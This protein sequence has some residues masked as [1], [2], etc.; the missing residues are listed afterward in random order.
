MPSQ[1]RPTTPAQ[2]VVNALP[3][4]PVTAAPCDQA[5][6][7]TVAT[8]VLQDGTSYQGIS[9]GAET[10]SIAGECVFQT[11]MVGYPE[12]LTDPSYRGQIL[13]LTFPLV[14]NYGVPSRELMDPILKDLPKYFESN[15]IHIA[16]LI[17]G[18]YSQDYSHYLATSSLG[19]WLKEY[20]IPAI[21]GIDTRAMTKKIRSQGVMLGKILF[22]T[23]IVGPTVIPAD[24]EWMKDYQNVDWVDPNARNLVAEVSLKEPKIYSPEPTKALL[25]P[26]GKPL[27]I[28]A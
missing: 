27:R 3:H 22:P 23:T 10:K 20:N 15:E 16:G 7:A 26:N 8:L 11:G 2:V 1:I 28:L 12:S 9:F 14:G 24:Y 4:P 18:Q 21:Y 17:V 5:A 13:V 25:G 6:A 19:A